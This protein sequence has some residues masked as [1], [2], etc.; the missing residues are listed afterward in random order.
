MC[1]GVGFSKSYTARVMDEG[2]MEC[3]SVYFD[4]CVHV[5]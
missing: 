2:E 3:A 5:C 1:G 4:I